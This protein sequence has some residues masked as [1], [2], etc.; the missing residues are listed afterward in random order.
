MALRL[1][2]QIMYLKGVGPKLGDLFNRKGLKTLR[3]LFEF[4]PRAY[5]DQR[6]AR[7]IASL[8]PD[9][10]VSIKA[11]VVAVHS[12][13]M[14]RSTRKMYDVVVKDAS[15][16]IHCKYFRVP[17]KGYF[18]RFKPFT[19]VRVVG[20]VTEYRGRIEFHHPDIRDIEPD[21]ETQDALIPLYTEI[22]GLATAKIQ[23]LVRSA[24]AQIEEW[25]EE[26][27]PKWLLQKYELKSRKD[28]LKE[29]HFPDPAK[30]A[31]YAEF[32]TAAQRR[33]IFEEFFWLE[34]W[35]ASRKAG[36]QKEG[37]PKIE[38]AGHKLAALEKSLPYQLTGAQKKVF[39]QIKADLE[40]GH[41]M[42]RLVQGDV[43]SGKTLVSFMAA[44]YAM[45]SGFQSCL[46]APTE[47]LAEQ[48]FKNAQKVLA[49]LGVR[50]GLL[51]GKT[52]ASER[53]E[54]L[55]EL[56]SGEIDLIIGTHAL[57]ED[58][59]VFS[60]L[61][62]AIIDEQ[63]RF[64]VEQ[65]GVL[66]NKGKSPHFLIMTA[67]PIPR[68]L[69]MT[70]YGDLDVSIIDEMPPGRSPIQTRA[71][72]DSKRPQALQFMLEQ[73]QKGR[74]AYFVYPLVE[75]S[76]K[77][78]LKNAVSEFEKLQQQFPQVKFGLLH[79]KMKP[80]EKDEVMNQFRRH[81]IQVLVSTTVIE[82]G[83]DVPNAN[84]MIIE[85][86]ER[87]GLSQLHQLRGRVGRGE[88]KSFCILIMGYAVSEEGKQRTEMMEKTSDGFKIAEFDLE[89]RGPGEFMG[90]RQS[91]LAGFKL[92][93]LVRDM[94][95]L[96]Q[97]REAAFEVLKKDPKLSFQ[98]NKGL[99]EELLR[100]HGPA[101]LAGIA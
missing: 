97:A 71:I 90:T 28:A 101:A 63:H 44:L 83:V 38:N 26:A 84:I 57:I 95:I 61:G 48:H 54:L 15:G 76:E 86:A 65:R 58:E 3:D 22:E 31:E 75:E 55:F 18:E 23:K 68:T 69:A 43:G 74:Q 64:G 62:L 77:I 13:N 40:K 6:A 80:A 60:N 32:K 47:I 96:Q 53:K 45:E 7:N 25:P 59:V 89:M 17:Y 92:A 29:M 70:V 21:E 81:E 8:K 20:K 82:V 9:D 66:K 41:P 35:L 10:I 34:L 67:T 33:I 39:A 91:G 73:L 12:I 94:A 5:E 85:H 36:F 49:P 11:T 79:G 78:D 30:A 19:E 51:V 24:F 50:L 98:D 56:Q 93:N 100:E 16:Q 14:G 99:R 37:A 46:M 52:K 88:H 72:F 2:T 42:H 1:D 4:Y 27:L 87:F